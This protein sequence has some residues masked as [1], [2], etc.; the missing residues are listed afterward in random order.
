MVSVLGGAPY[1]YRYIKKDEGGGAASFEIVLDEA[2]VVRQVFR[3][4]GQERATIGEV[5]RRLTAAKE[6]TRM[7]RT[8]WDRTTV[9]D[10]LKNPGLY[11]HGSVWQDSGGVIGATS[12]GSTWAATPAASREKPS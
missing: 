12:A 8:V 6:R 11:G 9:W 10:M 1:G 7:G 2:R 4:V 3:W 5:V